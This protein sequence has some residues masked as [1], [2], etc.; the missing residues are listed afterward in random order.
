MEA[1]SLQLLSFTLLISLDGQCCEHLLV[2]WE[3]RL[4]DSPLPGKGHC[5]HGRVSL[6]VR[7]HRRVKSELGSHLNLCPAREREGLFIIHIYIPVPNLYWALCMCVYF[8][9][10]LYMLYSIHVLYTTYTYSCSLESLNV[11]FLIP[12]LY[13]RCLSSLTPHNGFISKHNHL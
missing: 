1:T 10:V 12:A 5:L 11:L 9:Y 4:T 7:N 6:P 3:S 2:A 8:T 13:A